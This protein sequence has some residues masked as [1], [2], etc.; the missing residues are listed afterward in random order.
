MQLTVFRLKAFRCVM[1]SL[2]EDKVKISQVL[3]TLANQDT[4]RLTSAVIIH[5]SKAGRWPDHGMTL[6]TSYQSY[7]LH[8]T[9]HT[10]LPLQSDN[11]NQLCPR[12]APV[13]ASTLAAASTSWT[14]TPIASNPLPFMTPSTPPRLNRPVFFVMMDP[15]SVI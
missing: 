11:A 12:A 7:S 2:S 3:G 13:G 6:I 4:G 9:L 15:S 14:S 1:G 10:P 8:F 5:P